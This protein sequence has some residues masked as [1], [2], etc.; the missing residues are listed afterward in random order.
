MLQ[1]FSRSY[2]FKR[3]ERQELDTKTF[4]PISSKITRAY[5]LEYHKY[6]P[7]VLRLKLKLLENPA[8]KRNLVHDIVERD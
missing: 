7:E 3:I 2:K 5:A 8:R 6:Y 1:Y 4:K